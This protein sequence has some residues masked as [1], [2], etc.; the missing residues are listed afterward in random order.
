M[1]CL[2]EYG[3]DDDLAFDDSLNPL[4]R[5]RKYMKSEV[6]LHRLHLVRDLC[7]ISK[8]VGYEK[9]FDDVMPALQ[10]LN[11]DP[12]NDKIKRIHECY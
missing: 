10:E 4:E 7:D 2:D 12:E 11:N 3:H 1:C 8:A 9:S 5:I 6:T